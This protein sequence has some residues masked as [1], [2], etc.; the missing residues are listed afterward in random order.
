MAKRVKTNSVTYKVS[1]DQ[2]STII[3]KIK[4]LTKLDNT[5]IMNFSNTELLLFSVV[6]KNLDNVHSFK[7]HTIP[8]K[9]VFAVNKNKL[10][11]DIR[12]ILTDGKRFVTSMS[13]FV[14]YMRAQKIEDDLDFKLYFNEEF[15]EKLLIKNPK[16]KEETPGGKPNNHTHRLDVDDIEDVMDTELASYSFELH[17][18]DFNYIK[19]KLGIEDNDILYLNINN[20]KL[21]IGENRWDHNICDLE[22]ED[23]TISFPKKYFKCINYDNEDAMKIYVTETMLLIIG[24]ST[25]LL[26]TIELTV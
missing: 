23:V 13:V 4:D 5:I 1:L 19:A 24:E 21:S 8:I 26:I 20:N 14:K 12:Y 17:K 2:L 7:S 18:D 3:E 22:Y 6:G 16:S 9:D 10:E 25:N 15:C 11:N